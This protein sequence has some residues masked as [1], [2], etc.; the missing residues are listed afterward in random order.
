MGP[1]IRRGLATL[2]HALVRS[3]S[4]PPALR[5]L[6]HAAM[7][8]GAAP[9]GD[10]ETAI[11][12]D[13]LAA[14][15]GMTGVCRGPALPHAALLAPADGLA[16]TLRERSWPPAHAFSIC[17]WVRLPPTDPAHCADPPFV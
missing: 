1:C 4:G 6:L 17:V 16:L 7:P 5:L 11:S 2:V 13:G 14:L 3:W 15:V 8:M 10:R 9:H 12:A